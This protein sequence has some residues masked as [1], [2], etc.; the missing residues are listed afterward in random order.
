VDKF[1][2]YTW[3]GCFFIASAAITF[4]AQAAEEVKTIAVVNG[5]KIGQDLLNQLIVNSIA[6]GAK[7]TPELRAALENELVV[8]EVLAQEARRLKLDQDAQVKLQMA[9][10]QNAL[11]AEALIT[12]QAEKFNISD[13]KL[14]SEYK[15]QADLLSDVEEYQ[16]SHIV[17]QTEGEAKALIKAIKGGEAF[18]KMARTK[19]IS[20]SAQNGGSLG[21]LLG[22]QITPAISNAV[23]NMSVGAVTSMP[24]AT[25]EGWQVIRVNDK[26]KYKVPAFEESRQQLISAVSANERAELIQKL[27][28]AANV[29]R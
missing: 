14:R 16:V 25:P 15:R 17:T 8:R 18:D 19:S 22:N 2:K 21:W 7:D 10:Q 27:V 26:R 11:L 3:L 5:T 9:L 12:K 28:K 13:E 24:I 4:S 23:V 20:P 1:L 6:Q 29:K